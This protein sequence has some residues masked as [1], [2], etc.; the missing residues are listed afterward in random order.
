M[1][2]DL[3][4]NSFIWMRSIFQ[5]HSSTAQTKNAVND[6]TQIQCE[7]YFQDI[8]VFENDFSDAVNH[9]L[10]SGKKDTRIDVLVKLVASFLVSFRDQIPPAVIDSLKLSK[11]QIEAFNEYRA[12]F[13]EDFTRYILKCS[14]V[15]D[16]VVR[17]RATEIIGE[18][19]QQLS[20]D[21]E[22]RFEYIIMSHTI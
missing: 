20:D 19:M 1:N 10:P 15:S 5:H 22:F 17:Q 16:K 9:I 2:V 6:I 12:N 11:A 18:I 13:S 21:C 7:Q 4:P 14:T 8:S 3:T